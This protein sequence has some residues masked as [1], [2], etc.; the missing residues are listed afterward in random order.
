MIDY[1]VMYGRSIDGQDRNKICYCRG[2]DYREI[3]FADNLLLSKDFKNNGISYG[4]HL[5]KTVVAD[6]IRTG[7][8]EPFWVRQPEVS[9]TYDLRNPAY[10]KELEYVK[11]LYFPVT[12]A[13]L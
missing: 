6:C 13:Q 9:Y 3:P 11:N 10:Q 1:P 7:S 5:N 2:K 4:L 8:N 12:G